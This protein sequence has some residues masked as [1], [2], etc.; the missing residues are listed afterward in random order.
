M[1]PQ[2]PPPSKSELGVGERWGFREVSHLIRGGGGITLNTW[3]LLRTF[4]EYPPSLHHHRPTDLK[5]DIDLLNSAMATDAI[6]SF[7]LARFVC[8]DA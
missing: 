1:P 4:L 2:P 5:I 3:L 6:C 8:K 7:L